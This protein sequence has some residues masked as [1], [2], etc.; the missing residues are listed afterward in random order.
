M[1]INLFVAYSN[2]VYQVITD[3]RNNNLVRTVP[4]HSGTECLKNCKFSVWFILIKL[5]RTNISLKVN[6]LYDL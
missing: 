3:I 5:M 6:I 1:I 4:D 2:V